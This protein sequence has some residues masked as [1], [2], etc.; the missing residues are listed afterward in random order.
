MTEILTSMEEEDG[1]RRK[2]AKNVAFNDYIIITQ[3]F[4]GFIPI[5]IQK[6]SYERFI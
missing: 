4:K 3:I 1:K 5:G 2:K 6:G